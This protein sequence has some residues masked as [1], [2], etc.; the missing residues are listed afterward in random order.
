M[1]CAVI[2]DGRTQSSQAFALYKEYQTLFPN[3]KQADM[4]RS[5]VNRLVLKYGYQ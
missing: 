1:N 2:L 4:V 5:A 3:G